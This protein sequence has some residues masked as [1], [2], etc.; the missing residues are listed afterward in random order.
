V[1]SARSSIKSVL[2]DSLLTAACLTYFGSMDLETCRRLLEDWHSRL[3]RGG[4][5]VIE[6]ST[7]TGGLANEESTESSALIVRENYALN[8]VLGLSDLLADWNASGRLSDAGS[9]NNVALL[10]SCMFHWDVACRWPLLVDP[11]SCA[12]T[13]IAALRELRK[14]VVFPPSSGYNKKM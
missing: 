1:K 9:Q 6:H 13:W 11:D 14:L 4:F 7:L 2:G 12:E 8:G 5:V 3:E 10:Y